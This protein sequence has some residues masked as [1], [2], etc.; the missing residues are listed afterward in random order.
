MVHRNE[1]SGSLHGMF[2][3]RAFTQDDLHSFVMPSQLKDEIKEHLGF[4]DS[5]FGMLGFEYEL[6]LSTRPEKA[7]GSDSI[8]SMAENYIKEALNELGKCYTIDEGGGAFYGP[9]IDVKIKDNHGRK[10]QL[11]T[12]QVDFNLPE[13]FDM[14]YIADDGTHQRP[15]MIHR[16]VAGS[17]ERFM[18][19]LLEHY[20]GLM[21]VA[22]ATY[23]VAIVPVSAQSA[24]QMHYINEVID[25][26][27]PLRAD[28][29]IYDDSNTFNK[30]IKN[31]EEDKNP[32]VMIIGDNEVKHRT[33]NLRH[34]I[35]QQRY[36]TS[37]DMFKY[38]LAVEMV[39][40]V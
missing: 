23:Q 4:I 20:S 28:C 6:N 5:L 33:V 12:I 3:V 9:K 38:A 13:R 29:R 15:V 17:I 18:G 31:A 2:R 34:K 35:K 27:K 32:I 37:L 22:L 16:A 24:D 26:L 11:S 7:I 40:V 36:E 10:W 21:P 39:F 30:R 19:I 25:M 14:Q 1:N 8:W